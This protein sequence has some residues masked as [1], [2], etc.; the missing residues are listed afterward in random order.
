MSGEEEQEERNLCGFPRPWLWGRRVYHI[1]EDLIEERGLLPMCQRHLD[2]DLILDDPRIHPVKL[3][4]WLEGASEL[5]LP[6]LCS[7]LQCGLS[8]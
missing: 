4:R 1:S 7:A 6:R 3:Y 5:W 8:V 2:E